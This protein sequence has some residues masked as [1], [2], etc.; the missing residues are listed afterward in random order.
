MFG[1]KLEQ[2]VRYFVKPKQSEN[3]NR[4]VKFKFNAGETARH[5]QYNIIFNKNNDTVVETL[6]HRFN[7]LIIHIVNYNFGLAGIGYIIL[8]CTNYYHVKLSCKLKLY[9]KIRFFLLFIFPNLYTQSQINCKH[10][11]HLLTFAVTY[12]IPIFGIISL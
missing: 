3:K 7:L 12:N 2:C 4:Y 9:L 11:F 10:V 8:D 6:Q 5:C 1:I